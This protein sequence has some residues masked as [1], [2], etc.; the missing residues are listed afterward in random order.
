MNDDQTLKGQQTLIDF[1]EPA[2]NGDSKEFWYSAALR[3]SFRIRI[4]LMIL[5]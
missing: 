3:N 4:I 2:L 5:Q 1:P